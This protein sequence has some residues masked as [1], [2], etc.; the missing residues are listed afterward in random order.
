MESFT[1][2]EL[3]MMSMAVSYSAGKLK[4]TRAATTDEA[5]LAKIDQTL[6]LLDTILDKLK[7]QE[8]LSFNG[9]ELTKIYV[10]LFYL[11]E[12]SEQALD[13][14]TLETRNVILDCKTLSNR[15]MRKIRSAIPGIEACL[16]NFQ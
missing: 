11:R 3:N 13:G 12:K 9:E 6:A 8:M 5:A 15:A 1:E 7:Q 16:Q 2:A 14:C 10:A 4:E